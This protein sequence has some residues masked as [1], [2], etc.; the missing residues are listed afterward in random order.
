MQNQFIDILKRR[1]FRFQVNDIGKGKVRL[2]LNGKKQVDKWNEE[3]GFSNPKH[4]KKLLNFKN[5]F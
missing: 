1:G 3:I 4:V 2:R 5:K